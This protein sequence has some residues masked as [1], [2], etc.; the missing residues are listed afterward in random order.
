MKREKKM[1]KPTSVSLMPSTKQALYKV[2]QDENRSISYVV[3]KAIRK[4]LKLPNDKN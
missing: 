1:I 3:E 2:C 4:Y